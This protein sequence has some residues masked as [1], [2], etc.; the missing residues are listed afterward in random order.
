MLPDES[1]CYTEYDAL[2]HGNAKNTVNVLGFAANMLDSAV[3]MVHWDELEERDLLG[4]CILREFAQARVTGSVN[5]PLDEL[6]DRLGDLRR[7]H[8]IS[9][10]YAVAFCSYVTCGILQW[11]ASRLGMLPRVTRD[12]RA[13]LRADSESKMVGQLIKV[14]LD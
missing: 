6:D 5:I 3:Q 8:R 1:N 14:Q 11:I 13:Y 4:I 7:G 12:Y 9:I 2:P 10:Y